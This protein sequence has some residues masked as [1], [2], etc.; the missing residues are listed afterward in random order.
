[1]LYFNTFIHYRNAK[2]S[3]EKIAAMQQ[4]ITKFEENLKAMKTEREETES[5]AKQL[6]T[7][8]QEITVQLT[9]GQEDY[10]GK[11]NDKYVICFS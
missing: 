4:D 7:C 11:Y 5:D 2:A 1:M 9:D 3:K 6:L 8:I 10:S